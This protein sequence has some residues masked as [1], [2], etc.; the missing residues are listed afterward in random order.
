MTKKDSDTTPLEDREREYV[1][2]GKGRKDEVGGSG[3]Y[4]VSSPEAP[5]DAEIRT[6]TELAKHKGPRDRK[7]KGFKRAI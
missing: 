7:P 1:R 4:P 2:G 3:I 5:V 6:E